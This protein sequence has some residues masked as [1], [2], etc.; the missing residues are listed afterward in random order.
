MAPPH[1]PH[2]IEELE[3]V[4]PVVPSSQ[5]AAFFSGTATDGVQRWGASL[6]L[7]V[8]FSKVRRVAAVHVLW[9]Q[10]GACWSWA[11]GGL[12]WCS[13]Q[14]RWQALPELSR[15]VAPCPALS[16]HHPHCS[17][18]APSPAPHPQVALLAATSLSWPLWWPWALATRKNIAVR[19]QLRWDATA[20]LDG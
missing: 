19:R 14:P 9:L 10:H 20:V 6:A 4:L 3:R 17:L 11:F 7:T 12:C 8:L 2:P 18:T 1:A 5:Q 13:L 16:C 15:P